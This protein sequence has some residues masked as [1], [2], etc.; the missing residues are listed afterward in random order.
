MI[1]LPKQLTTVT[2]FSKVLAIVLFI[3]F[4]F[5]GFLSGMQ[6]QSLLGTS[7]ISPMPPSIFPPPIEE[8]I[9]CPMDLKTCSDGSFVGRTPPRCEFRPCPTESN[10][11]GGYFQGKSSYYPDD[12]TKGKF[13]LYPPVE[14]GYIS[15]DAVGN[16]IKQHLECKF[17]DSVVQI[18][19]EASGRG[20]I[21]DR[22]DNVKLANTTWDRTYF[23]QQG[24]S[25]KVSY[26]AEIEQAYQL[27]EV[28]YEPYNTQAEQ[29]VE[30]VIATFEPIQ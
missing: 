8:S 19:P 5:I 4:P 15:D 18:Y 7:E 9:A 23:D 26:G 25:I 16:R 17:A 11:E 28:V 27:I 12:E 29:Q 20:A 22:K 30:K 13:A 10:G 3:L 6:Y 1:N 24:D 14:C 2:P 21:V